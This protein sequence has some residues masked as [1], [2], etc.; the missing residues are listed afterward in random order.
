LPVSGTKSVLVQRLMSHDVT[1][2][3]QGYYLDGLKTTC[4]EKLLVQSGTKLDLILRLLHDEFGTG[5]VKRA[6]TETVTDPA[7]GA[8][9]QVL[10]K[11]RA[12][13]ILQPATLYG[14]VQA[15][16]HAV[17]QK[18][19][20]SNYGSKC[21]APDTYNYMRNLLEEQIVDRKILV[22]DPL[23]AFAM[24]KAIFQAFYDHWS[25]MERPGYETSEFSQGVMGQLEIILTAVKSHLS[26]HQ[27]EEM[28][29]LL[30]GIEDSVSRYGLQEKN[31]Y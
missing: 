6:A 14:R 24:A 3:Y 1:R 11:K 21:H 12:K 4:K 25:Y 13:V 9:V 23:L 22:T 30:E 2:H 10:K 18:K 15:K 26:A 27:M 5:T 28:V 8:T 31:L 16:I 29:D 20:Q 7:T 17:A 19:Y